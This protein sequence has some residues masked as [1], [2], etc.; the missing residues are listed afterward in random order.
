M[1]LEKLN[2]GQQISEL[3]QLRARCLTA[4]EIVQRVRQQ[5]EQV[6]EQD[7]EAVQKR[8]AQSENQLRLEHDRIDREVRDQLE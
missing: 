1:N 2:L 4:R 7:K 8:T 6:A 5:R 3:E